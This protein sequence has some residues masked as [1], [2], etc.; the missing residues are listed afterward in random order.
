MGNEPIVQALRELMKYEMAMLVTDEADD[1]MASPTS[2]RSVHDN[3]SLR[4]SS[5]ILDHD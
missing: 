5:T 2:S 1:S 3:V 4:V